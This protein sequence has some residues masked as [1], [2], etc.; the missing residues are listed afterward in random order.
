MQAGYFKTGNG[1][2]VVLVHGSMNS[3]SQWRRLAD[4]LKS[5][6]TV[7]ATDLTGYGETPFPENP[8]AHSMTDE[9]NLIRQTVSA[10]VGDRTAVHIVAHSYGGALALRYVTRYPDE[11]LSLNLFEPMANHL[12][13]NFEKSRPFL[14]GRRVI[15]TIS[16]Q[17]ASGDA[18][19]GA[20]LFVDYFSGEGI[21]GWLPEKAQATLAGYVHKMLVD[22]R[23][24]IETSLT[25]DDYRRI[26]CPFR[27]MTGSESSDV[28]LAVSRILLDQIPSIQWVEIQ[29]SHMAPIANPQA[30]NPVVSDWLQSM[31]PSNAR[32]SA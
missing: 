23:T 13:L 3:K 7:I 2:P 12:L 14:E 16:D 10:L 28:S 30:Y 31:A 24:T 25:I 8:D 17:V 18:Q 19:S 29:G 1:T 32:L 5:N 27:L 21:F 6:H 11:V 22:Y 9:V 15:E 4:V 20:R 26:G